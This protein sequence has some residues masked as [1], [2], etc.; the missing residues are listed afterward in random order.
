MKVNKERLIKEFQKLV[1]ID[2]PTHGEREIGTYVK[3]RMQALGFQVEEDD[4]GMKLGGNCGNIYGFLPGTI[5][6]EP[7]LFS[8]HMDTVEP[9]SGKKAVIHPDGKITSAGDTILGADDAAAIA[10]ILEA[11]ESIQEQGIDYPSIEVLFSVAEEIYCR[12]A[13]VFDFSKIKSKRAYVFDLPG[14]IGIAANK[15]PA[16]VVFTVMIRGKASHA[17]F[18]P[19]EGCHA[20]LAASRAISRIEMGHVSDDA[21]V[22]VGLIKG[23]I[24]TN[25]VPELCEVRGEIRSY[26]QREAEELVLATK[27]VFEEAA[28]EIGAKAEFSYHFDCYPYAHSENCPTIKFFRKVCEDMGLSGKLVS[29]FG[30]SDNN[31]F[32]KNGME[33]IVI[34]NA[35]NQCHSL[36]EYTSIDDLYQVAV[37]A[38]RLMIYSD[39][40]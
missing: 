26:S 18:A 9:S 1:S 14:E 22:N 20:V 25:I 11:V 4:A 3:N 6:G 40:G 32:A 19:E 17:G 28:G 37:L 23:G 13:D 16:I 29:S 12:G 10:E 34:T 31:I 15:A 33:G 39:K 36:D 30:G 7:I 8:G 21:V 35:M 2:S 27:S 24:A 38:A 5:D